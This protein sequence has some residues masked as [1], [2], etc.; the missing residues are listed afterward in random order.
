MFEIWLCIIDVQ[1]RGHELPLA[2][3]QYWESNS[4]LVAH[5]KFDKG[6]RITLRTPMEDTPNHQTSSWALIG[7]VDCSQTASESGLLGEGESLQ[8]MVAHFTLTNRSRVPNGQTLCP[9]LH[10]WLT[11]PLVAWPMPATARHMPLAF[12]LTKKFRRCDKD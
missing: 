2:P 12:V 11:M 8:A 9:I 6:S 3:S 4:L 1:L 10:P 7:E 5:S